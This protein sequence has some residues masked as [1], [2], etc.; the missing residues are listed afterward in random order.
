MQWTSE[1]I[2]VWVFTR[3]SIPPDITNL[4]PNPSG[5]GLPAADMQGSCPIDVHFQQHK[6]I[7]DN[8]FC[9]SYAGIASVW[10]S[11]INS[12]AIS[13][14]YPDCNSFVAANPS[15]FTNA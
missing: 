7:F 2:K 12:C 6:I 11:T 14:G 9:G 5:W 4:M 13:T 15:A 10:N 8:T 3:D 1:Y